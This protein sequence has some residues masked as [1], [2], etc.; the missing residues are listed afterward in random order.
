VVVVQAAVAAVQVAMFP[1]PHKLFLLAM[2]TQ[3]PW[4]LALRLP[5]GLLKVVAV[6]I[7]PLQ[8]LPPQLAVAL[9][10]IKIQVFLAV[11]VVVVAVPYPVARE[12]L[13]KVI[14]AVRPLLHTTVAV[15]AVQVLLVQ[16]QC[17]MTAALVALE[18]RP[19]LP[20]HQ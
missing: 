16:T 20:A 4:A 6:P 13:D 11:L 7:R 14:L 15:A 3:S 18:Q 19:R 12:H 1:S 2:C 10:R 5:E 9:G 8:G 17:R